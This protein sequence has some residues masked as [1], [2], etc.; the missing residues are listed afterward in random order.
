MKNTQHRIATILL[1]SLVVVSF[2]ALVACDLFYDGTV[3]PTDVTALAGVGSGSV[4]LTWTA[5]TAGTYKGQ[6]TKYT[7]YWSETTGVTTESTSKLDVNEATSGKFD[8]PTE[9]TVTGLTND[10]KYYFIVTATTAAGESGASDEVSKSPSLILN[11][12]PSGKA[13]LGVVRIDS[14]V[15]GVVKLDFSPID[16]DFGSYDGKALTADDI[17][18]TGYAHTVELSD[19]DS[20]E[21]T[22]GVITVAAEEEGNSLHFTGLESGTAYNFYM[23]AG[24]VVGKGPLSDKVE[25]TSP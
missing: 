13:T 22:P 18:Y 15:P 6:T 2:F 14:S 9:I 23:T 4:K 16:S 17:E 1:S 12:A 7:V 10:K 8:P 21:N 11:A 24:N 25:V 19:T 20:A 3:V 5:P